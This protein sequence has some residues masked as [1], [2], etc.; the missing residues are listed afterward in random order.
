MMATRSDSSLQIS[1]DTLQQPY[2]SFMINGC[3][4]LRSSKDVAAA[5]RMKRGRRQLVCFHEWICIARRSTYV[6]ITAPARLLC[7][8]HQTTNPGTVHTTVFRSMTRNLTKS[9]DTLVSV[10]LQ[11]LLVIVMVSSHWID[12]L[13]NDTCHGRF[14]W[15]LWIRHSGESCS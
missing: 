2:K 15:D 12:G 1:T 5:T 7:L 4:G 13:D 8:H 3:V 11:R 10:P 6:Q 14:Y 9:T